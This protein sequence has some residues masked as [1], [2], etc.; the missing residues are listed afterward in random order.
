MRASLD[1]PLSPPLAQV[2]CDPIASD[3]AHLSPLWW[4]CDHGRFAN[5]VALCAKYSTREIRRPQGPAGT[6]PAEQ[7]ARNKHFQL[8]AWLG[9]EVTRRL[10][11]KGL[12]SG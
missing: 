4:A 9:R 10:K 1:P 8:A 5:A 12:D 11:S 7:A 6:T 3:R 2:G